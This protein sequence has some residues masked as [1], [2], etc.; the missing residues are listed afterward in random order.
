MLPAPP[1]PAVGYLLLTVTLQVHDDA[2]N[3]SAVTS[4]EGVRLLPQGACGF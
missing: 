1:L 2:G 4:D 3:I